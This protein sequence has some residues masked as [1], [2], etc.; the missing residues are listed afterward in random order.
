MNPTDDQDF[1]AF[2]KAA[3]DKSRGAYASL[4]LAAM[5]VIVGIWLMVP[6]FDTTPPPLPKVFADG[7]AWWG[8][9]LFTVGML[10]AYGYY[11]G[12]RRLRVVSDL[13]AAIF[14]GT[15]CFNF[16][17]MG[18]LGIATPMTFAVALK[19]LMVCGL[20]FRGTKF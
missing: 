20:N 4:L 12:R 17:S 2:I 9:L 6:S 14:W 8:F 19:D 3:E 7:E 13:A 11:F 5:D 16:L 10:R 15:C 1:R 18:W